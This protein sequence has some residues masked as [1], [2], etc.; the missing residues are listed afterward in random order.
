AQL[1]RRP[2]SAPRAS[3]RNRR[4]AMPCAGAP[5]P[6]RRHRARSLRFSYRR[7]RCRYARR[8]NLPSVQFGEFEFDPASGE[9]RRG[10]AVVRLEPQ[11]ARVL[12][13]LV[14]RAGQVVT[15]TE[16]QQAVWGG[17]TFVDFEHGLTYCIAQIRT[18]LGDSAAAPRFIETLPRR[19]YRFMARATVVAPAS[20]SAAR[21]VRIGPLWRRP[22]WVAAV[23]LVLA[24]AAIWAIVA[25][26]H[27]AA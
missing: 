16:L 24:A 18:A 20:C 27:P 3:W 9:L 14:E 10:S 22:A 2:R 21:A 1:R 26:R 4:A 15:R 6:L 25:R 8:C 23:A 11:P 19:G 17:E 7:D 12:A 5:G 13:H